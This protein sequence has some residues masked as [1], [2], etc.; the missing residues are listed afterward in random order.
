MTQQANSGLAPRDARPKEQVVV[1]AIGE[2]SFVISASSVQEIRSTDS[3]G[4]NVV[5]LDRPVL[6]KVRHIVERDARSYYVVSGY[7]HFHLP[8]SRPTSVLILRNVPVAVLVDRIEEMAEMRVLLGLPRSF[9]GEER[10]WY[11]GVTVLGHKVVPVAEPRGF[12]TAEELRC[13]E[14][15]NPG[16]L[17]T[18]VHPAGTSRRRQGE[19]A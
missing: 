9:S 7:E 18:V 12:L 10:T 17:Q 3:L 4:G 19:R 2:Q 13:L 15:E 1:F 14:E 16:L 6:P 8:L 11:R 5:E